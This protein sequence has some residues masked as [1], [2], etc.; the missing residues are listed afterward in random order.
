MRTVENKREFSA[1]QCDMKKAGDGPA[2]S[3][4]TIV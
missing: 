1:T 2:Q 4:K 3:K